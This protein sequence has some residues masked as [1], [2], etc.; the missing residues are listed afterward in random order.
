MELEP[1]NALG[2][3][4]LRDR[5]GAG[6]MGE[7]YR[8]VDPRLGREVAVKVLPQEAA[9][10]PRALA[11]F[12]REARAVAALSHPNV[13]V[14]HDV[15][16]QGDVHYVVTELLDG[17]SLLS[18]LAAGP[19]PWRPAVALA[20]EAA[21]GLQAAHARGIVHRD[22]KPANL[23]LTRD[24]HLKIL[25]FGV[26][27]F[28]HGGEPAGDRTLP[29][30]VLGS[31]GYMS[32]E[33]A[34]GQEVDGRSDLFSLG[35]VLYEMLCCRRAFGGGSLP[36][37]MAALARDQP[38]ALRE[39]A[40]E[41]PEELAAVVERCLRKRPAE[42]YG[43]AA[44]LAFA[45]RSLLTTSGERE[46]PAV[47]AVRA[48]TWMGRW[49]RALASLPRRRGRRSLAVL[50]FADA[51][52]D[53]DGEYLADGLTESIIRM[54][55]GL[56]DLHVM[57]WSTVAHL[58]GRQL[59][60]RAAA[61]TLGVAV[62]LVGRVAERDGELVVTAEL[63]DGS[64]GKCLWAERYSRTA[65]DLLE[66]QEQ[67]A[68][69]LSRRLQTRLSAPDRQR[70][71]RRFTRDPEA[72]RLYLKGRYFWNRRGEEGLA[73]SREHFRAAIERDPD[74]ALAYAGLSDALNVLP[75]WGLLPPAEAFVQGKA[76]ARTAL[77]LDPGLAEAHAALAY[78]LFWFDW[79]WPA[80]QAEFR[81]ALELDPSYATAHHWYGVALAATGA[82]AAAEA[83]L[84]LAEEIEP[85]AMIVRADQGLV[86]YWQG[87]WEGACARCRAV[88]D[89]DPDFVPAHL[90][91]G[92][93]REQLGQTQEA[94]E[95]LRRAAA[96][97]GTNA[98]AALAHA[99]ATAGERELARQGLAQLVEL[100]GRRYVSP[101][102]LGVLHAGL[103]E[104]EAALEW[105]ERGADARCEMMPWLPRDPRLRTLAGQPRF[106]ALARRVSLGRS[107]AGLP[108]TMVEPTA[109]TG[110]P[111][112]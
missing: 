24:G 91:L 39:L 71:E 93:A 32:P 16:A 102:L 104:P 63:V 73:R 87:D 64:S 46:R 19:L 77:E 30:S 99:F 44:E 85:L 61:G 69:Q 101:Y 28:T 58:R 6:A 108:A 105:L 54:L 51:A 55:S 109:G 13:L 42:R 27:R 10:S 81:V 75:F 103:G 9:A 47:P 53:P 37:T 15:G 67:I 95:A 31:I 112:G 25:D 35:C 26:A 89:L 18:R 12:E 43:T 68:R 84:R 33:Q 1:G 21:E 49:L 57:A 106:Q 83:S 111:S 80:A 97:G 36:E 107:D 74:Y 65:D 23:F 3:Y 20:A 22:L 70:L 52:G 94:L 78:A 100:A 82:F 41:V 60:P 110:P 40:P 4:V 59:D 56:P 96:G 98:M 88:L 72:Y 2:P 76:A 5:L 50:P 92:L 7:V 48:G 62:V 34:A 66:V 17:E 86:R 90:Y 79:E 11:R 38:P 8:A 45:L 14:V 29:G